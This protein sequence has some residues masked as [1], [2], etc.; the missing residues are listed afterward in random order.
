MNILDHHDGSKAVDMIDLDFQK[1][2]DK[3]PLHRL[4]IKLKSHGIQ[5]DVSRRLENCLNNRKQRVLINGKACE[6]TN[7]T[8]GVLQ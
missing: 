5:G 8:S 1:P 2:F 7:V 6:W 4:L 3:V